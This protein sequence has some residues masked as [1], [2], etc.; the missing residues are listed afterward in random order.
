MEGL[1]DYLALRPKVLCMIDPA[2]IKINVW[3]LE[4]DLGNLQ[5]PFYGRNLHAAQLNLECRIV[6][7]D[8]AVTFKAAFIG[9][10]FGL[11]R[12]DAAFQAIATLSLALASVDESERHSD[13]TLRHFTA[14]IA[15]SMKTP[16]ALA[17]FL[18]R[19]CKLRDELARYV[20]TTVGGQLEDVKSLSKGA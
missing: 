17:N 6:C 18:A 11:E 9:Y 8:T 2:T 4:S 1:K 5:S 13:E 19:R 7:D 16:K 3:P 12:L 10:G 15:Q 20:Q 14:M